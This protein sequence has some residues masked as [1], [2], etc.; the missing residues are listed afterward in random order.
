[1]DLKIL[2]DEIIDQRLERAM[3]SQISYCT[4]KSLSPLC[5]VP[6][7]DKKINI[8][9]EYLVV[10]KYRVFTKEDLGKKFALISNDGGQTFFYLYQASEPQ[11]TNGVE[12]KF[13]GTH[14]FIDGS[15][16]CTLHGTTSDGKSVVITHGTIEK[17]DGKIKEVLHEKHINKGGGI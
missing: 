8:K 10:P 13:K 15:V 7:Y 5:F 2:I 11:G 14:E 12:Y 6:E 9:E 1:M 4:L 3:R 16:K 17:Y